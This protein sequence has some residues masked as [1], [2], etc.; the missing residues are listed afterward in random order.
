MIFI[1]NFVFTIVFYA[2]R[3][4]KLDL[5]CICFQ[6]FLKHMIYLTHMIFYDHIGKK[7]IDR[8]MHRCFKSSLFV[9]SSWI[10]RMSF[11]HFFSLIWFA[12]AQVVSSPP[13][14]LPGAIS[15]PVDVATLPHRVTL[16]FHG[17]K[18]SSSLLLH[19]L[20][21]LHPVASPLEPKPSIASTPLNPVSIL[22]HP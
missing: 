19:F 10:D 8:F 4:T 15:P 21:T 5:T 22:L 2:M 17:A 3:W 18:T 6:E 12:W 13:F 14:P 20:A 11:I 1:L 9:I 7:N 16:P